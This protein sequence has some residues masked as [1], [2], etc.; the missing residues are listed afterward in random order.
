[1]TD[2]CAFSRNHR[3]VK[4]DDYEII[5][6]E[7]EEADEL[8]HGNRIEIQHL[9]EYIAAL[10]AIL[11]EKALNIRQRKRFGKNL[12]KLFMEAWRGNGAEPLT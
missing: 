5:R 2:Y 8:C 7:L 1:M 12:Q 9:R 6:H 11:D 4:W 10:Q 3:C